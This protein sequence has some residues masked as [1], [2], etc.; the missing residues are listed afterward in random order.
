MAVRNVLSE[1]FASIKLI[2]STNYVDNN[3]SPKMIEQKFVEVPYLL[4]STANVGYAN[5][6]Q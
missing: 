5:F 3:L 4:S 2:L 1:N 6:L